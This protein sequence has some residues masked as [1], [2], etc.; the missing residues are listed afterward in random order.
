MLVILAVKPSFRSV[1]LR[2]VHA[3]TCPNKT[4]SCRHRQEENMKM[5]QRNLEC[6]FEINSSRQ[7]QGL[8]AEFYNTAMNHPVP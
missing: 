4:E 7:E 3:K 6:S 2:L 8:M 1:S 5:N